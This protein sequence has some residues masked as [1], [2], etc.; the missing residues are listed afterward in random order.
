MFV[1]SL[2]SSGRTPRPADQTHWANSLAQSQTSEPEASRW[3]CSGS[4]LLG[5][6]FEPLCRLHLV[7]HTVHGCWIG[8]ARNALSDFAYRPR[9]GPVDYVRSDLN[10]ARSSS[11]KILGSSQAAK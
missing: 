3:R 4:G 10:P 2:W 5:D 9:I 6:S 7:S 11:V 1:C 8:G